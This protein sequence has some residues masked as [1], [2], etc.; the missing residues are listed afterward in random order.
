VGLSK[1]E[2][3]RRL[4]VEK[5][6]PLF[7]QRGYEGCSMA[8]VMAATGLE[9]GGVYRHFRSK[10]ELA[11]EVF[12][13]SVA[14]SMRARIPL[15]REGESALEA[16]RAMVQQFVEAPNGVAGGCPLMN[17]AIDSDDGNPKLRALARRGFAAWRRR[18]VQVVRCG[19]DEGEIAAEVDPMWLADTLIA[20]L[21]GALM[22]SRLEGRRA[23]LLHAQRSLGA[24]LDSVAQA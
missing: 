1:G 18:I 23:P 7:N 6:A 16:L 3:T 21:E 22:L 24:V 10:E 19:Q 2:E 14:R 9:K 15:R 11:Q 13:Y 5:S 4:I 12:R 8:D 17:T 20:Q